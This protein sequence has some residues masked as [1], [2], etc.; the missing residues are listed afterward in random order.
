MGQENF[1]IV[2]P[3]VCKA[4]YA[5]YF[6]HRH[7]LGAI[8]T[9]SKTKMS[10]KHA[11]KLVRHWGEVATQKIMKHFDWYIEHSL[12]SVHERP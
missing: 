11:N 10:I 2:I 4:I 8:A 3:V 12:M 6:C 7:E 9:E 5:C 1:D